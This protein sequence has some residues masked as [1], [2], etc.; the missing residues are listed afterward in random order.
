[1]LVAAVDLLDVVDAALPVGAEG[2]DEERHTGAYVG[3]GHADAAQLVF[4]VEADDGGA[5]GVAEDDLGAHVDEFVDEE[6]AALE[7]LLVDEDAALGL[8]GHD[9]GDADEV[10]GEAGPRGVGHGHDA[11]VHEALNLVVLLGGDVEVVAFLPH[12]DAEAAEHLWDEAEVLHLGVLDG[13]VALGHGG[14]ADEGAHLDHVGQQAVFAAVQLLHAA[15]GEQVAPHAADAGAHAVE[16]LA[17]LVDVRF[18]GGVHDGGGAVGQHGGHHDVGGAGDGG[19]V[20]EHVA[21]F[22]A[23]GVDEVGAAFVFDGGAE[24]LH[25]DEVGVEAPAA[26]LVA[27]GLGHHGVAEA[28]EEGTDEHDASAQGAGL[29]TV[30]GAVQHLEVD[31][32]GLEFEGATA[33]GG[34]GDVLPHVDAQQFEQVDE[35]V[36]VAYVGD[37]ADA[38][39]LRGE[40][41][42]TEHLQG[43]VLG[44]LGHYLAFQAPSSDDFKASHLVYCVSALSR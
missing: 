28:R 43:F 1:M 14:H 30:F 22:E 5:V 9:E 8:G 33:F 38:Y 37:V 27:A 16:H 29:L 18:A 40:E 23:L 42:G 19:F 20:E 41:H 25:A 15:D 44:A 24:A 10:G 36:D 34:G 32:V 13:E 31:L 11:S 35:A 6:E 12:L 3:R 17:E 21:A 39:L 4:A 2:C 7:H 26:Y